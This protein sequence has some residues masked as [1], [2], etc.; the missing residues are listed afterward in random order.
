MNNFKL[1]S[2]FK[3]DG[4][5][6]Q[7]FPHNAVHYFVSYYDYGPNRSQTVAE[8]IIRPTGLL[9]PKI[10]VRPSKDQIADLIPEIETTTIA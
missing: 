6:K 5:F 3:P 2:K 7:F 9:D 10:D 8:Q 1:Q 4:K